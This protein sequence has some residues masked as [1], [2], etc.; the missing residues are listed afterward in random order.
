MDNQATLDKA[1]RLMRQFRHTFKKAIMFRNRLK[2]FE[3]YSPKYMD[4]YCLMRQYEERSQAI[5]EQLYYTIQTLK[6]QS[7]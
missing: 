1:H 4:V 7:K 2:L 6:N 3:K 5:D